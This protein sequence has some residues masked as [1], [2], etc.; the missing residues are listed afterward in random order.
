MDEQELA[1][2]AREYAQREPWRQKFGKATMDKLRKAEKLKDP[3][4]RERE[5]AE[6]VSDA[7]R[8]GGREEL[9][10]WMKDA[11]KANRDE[12]G[13]NVDAKLRAIGPEEIEAVGWDLR[14]HPLVRANWS[15][16][17]KDGKMEMIAAYE[18]DQPAG[19]IN[20][21][22]E[23]P[24]EEE[25]IKE[26][27]GAIPWMHALWTNEDYRYRGI[28][29]KLVLAC[30]QEVINS[31]NLPK[32]I[33]LAVECENAIARGLYEKLGYEHRKVGGKDTFKPLPEFEGQEPPEAILMIKNLAA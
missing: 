6:I 32:V 19:R 15:E 23:G 4:E 18:E 20:L 8:Q 31:P 14:I 22:F 25:V 11:A 3:I 16:Q 28:G 13:A 10:G 27:G 26:L 12:R 21:I 29:T 33:G 9:L 7:R 1:R 24:L 17:I 2:R 30:E 5:V